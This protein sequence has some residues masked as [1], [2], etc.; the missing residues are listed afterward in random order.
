MISESETFYECSIIL[1][2]D[3]NEIGNN[4]SEEIE[5]IKKFEKNKVN[6]SL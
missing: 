3:G 1:L 6:I 5:K 4:F 2:T